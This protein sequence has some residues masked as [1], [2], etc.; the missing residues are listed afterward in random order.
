ML[1]LIFLTT[2]VAGAECFVKDSV[3]HVPSGVREIKAYEFSDRCDFNRIE[4]SGRGLHKIGDYAFL[5]CVELKEVSLPEGVTELGEG[6]FRECEKLSRIVFPTSLT[7]IPKAVCSWDENLREV[8]LGVNT[9]DIGSH[10]F[11][12]CRSL[13]TIVIPRKVTHVGSNVFSCC[14][15]LKEVSLPPAVR[16]LESYVFSGCES[17]ERVVLPANGALLGELIFSGC[18]NLREIYELSPQVP[19]FDCDS[20]PAEPDSEEFYE[21]CVLIVKRGMES[22]YSKARGWGLFVHIKEI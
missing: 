5:G 1:C 19:A 16:E 8:S 22:A 21:R 3:L 9:V 12:Y 14:R 15:L 20:Y 13:E 11:A 6:C 17:L 18:S 7:R 4:F 2:L 10:S